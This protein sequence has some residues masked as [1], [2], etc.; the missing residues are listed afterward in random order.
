MKQIDNFCDDDFK[1]IMYGEHDV[2]RMIK[3]ELGS[4][5]SHQKYNRLR[6]LVDNTLMILDCIHQL[7][8][9]ISGVKYF[10]SLLYII[11]IHVKKMVKFLSQEFKY[12]A[13]IFT[14]N[15]DIPADDEVWGDVQEDPYLLDEDVYLE[16]LQDRVLIGIKS[17]DEYDDEL[18]TKMLQLG[19]KEP[20]RDVLTDPT[21]IPKIIEHEIKLDNCREE[22]KME[23]EV[24]RTT[25]KCKLKEEIEMERTKLKCELEEER[26]IFN[27]NQRE[28]KERENKLKE[29]EN[30]LE[31][32]K[33][34]L[35]NLS[36]NLKANAQKISKDLKIIKKTKHELVKKYGNQA[37][38]SMKNDV[39]ET[40]CV[41]CL[42]ENREMVFIPCGHICSCLKC[43]KK[44]KDCP[45]CR[46]KIT[47]SVRF[48][49]A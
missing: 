32:D 39:Q 37:F 42:D 41:I 18:N 48:Y 31:K 25:L 2:S 30:K 3:I 21:K 10:T 15:T 29:R 43:A 27:M 38:K 47:H 44:L 34:V 13:T 1:N 49:V 22:I 16:E 8:K 26:S 17:Y 9:N 12:F 45:M 23:L 11:Q 40:S 36:N 35:F 20:Y 46:K 7:R 14:R 24:E 6:E 19:S 5:R 4:R 33:A 28:L